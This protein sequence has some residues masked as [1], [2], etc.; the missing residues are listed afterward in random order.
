MH[1]LEEIQRKDPEKHLIISQFMKLFASIKQ[2]IRGIR[3]DYYSSKVFA[4]LQKTPEEDLRRVTKALF[5]MYNSVIRLPLK[6]ETMVREGN[7]GEKVDERLIEFL[8]IPR[9][10]IS[11]DKLVKIADDERIQENFKFL[12]CHGCLGHYNN[13][14]NKKLPEDSH[15]KCIRDLVAQKDGR[16][17]YKR[18]CSINHGGKF[19]R[20]N[21]ED[22]LYSI[23][24]KP[25]ECLQMIDTKLK[26]KKKFAEIRAEVETFPN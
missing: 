10:L 13:E 1:L 11:K 21:G 22:T 16:E 14:A 5:D 23:Y 24:F 4:T 18:L 19:I 25:L 8:I 2:A 7:D 20:E 6:D 9:F 3:S 17:K 12:I 15:I 26:K